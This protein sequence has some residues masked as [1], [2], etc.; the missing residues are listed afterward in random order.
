MKQR[1]SF[2]TDDVGKRPTW[3]QILKQG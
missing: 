2:K 3:V 1:K